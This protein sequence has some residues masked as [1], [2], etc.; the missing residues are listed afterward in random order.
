MEAAISA[1]MDWPLDVEEGR[2]TPFADYPL[3]PVTVIDV[4]GMCLF[5]FP[6][7]LC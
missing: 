5:I 1:F 2:E 6:W 7:T 3:L 4:F